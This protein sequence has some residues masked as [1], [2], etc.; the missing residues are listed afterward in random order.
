VAAKSVFDCGTET[1]QIS[2]A[3]P[4]LDDTAAAV[5]AS[6]PGP[7]A[8][9]QSSA[10][11]EQG[12]RRDPLRRSPH[13]GFPAHGWLPGLRDLVDRS[14]RPSTPA[15]QRQIVLVVSGAPGRI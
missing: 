2:A 3:R 15:G 12:V 11:A 5:A 1:S 10:V 13:D 9:L 14:E 8:P 4:H 6:N 7:V